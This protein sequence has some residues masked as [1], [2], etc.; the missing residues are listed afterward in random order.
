M[1]RYTL[2]ALAFASMLV[3]SMAWA[4]SAAAA[5]PLWLLCLPWNTV[6]PTRYSDQA[7]TK[8]SGTGNWES[9]ALGAGQSDTV[10]IV[11]FSLRLED[12][13]K[14]GTSAIKCNGTGSTGWGLITGPNLGLVKVAEIKEAGKNCERI[15]GGCKTGESITEV[16]GANLPWKVHLFETEK[17]PGTEKTFLTALESTT[18]KK[19]PGWEITCK[20]A[21]GGTLTDKCTSPENEPEYLELFNLVQGSGSSL[22]LLVRGRFEERSPGTCTLGGEKAGK[23]A[24]LIAILLWKGLGLSINPN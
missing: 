22:E 17:V 12:K 14:G 20:A 2:I 10:R 11:G 13:I 3:M 6:N 18:E 19:P 9:A 21:V 16:K 15:E 23:I 4:G 24:G 8:A 1:S 5:G 7:C